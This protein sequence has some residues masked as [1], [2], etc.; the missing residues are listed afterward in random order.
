MQ[1]DRRLLPAVHWCWN[2]P[3]CSSLGTRSLRRASSAPLLHHSKY[4]PFPQTGLLSQPWLGLAC[5]AF[6]W[7]NFLEIRPVFPTVTFY[8][9]SATPQACALTSLRPAENSQGDL[10][11]P[12]KFKAMLI[13][14]S[15]ENRLLNIHAHTMGCTGRVIYVK[16]APQMN[17]IVV[18]C[19]FEKLK[20][21]FLV[22]ALFFFF[23]PHKF[24][25]TE[26]IQ[27]ILSQL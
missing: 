13:I 14:L 2:A 10:T 27:S 18:S 17:W 16:T 22:R 6:Y 11:T 15:E 19:F 9:V 25:Q 20:L 23:S 3:W 24:N 8:K 1:A 7:C 21:F 12:E 4:L 26:R 5:R